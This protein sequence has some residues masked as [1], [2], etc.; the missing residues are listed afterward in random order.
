MRP[1]G[2]GG[3]EA[4][5]RDVH[6]GPSVHARQVDARQRA[7]A[8]GRDPQPRRPDR[9]GGPSPA[10]SRWRSRRGPRPA[11]TPALAAAAAAGPI[12]PSPPGD[13]DPVRSPRRP[14]DR[15]RPG[16]THRPRRQRHGAGRRRRR[17]RPEPESGVP[18]Q[19]YAHR[20]PGCVPG[21]ASG[22]W[23][24]GASL[25]ALRRAPVG[26]LARRLEGLLQQLARLAGRLRRP[27]SGLP[28]GVLS[29]PRWACR[30]ILGS[31]NASTASTM[32][33]PTITSDCHPITP[34][35]SL[36]TPTARVPGPGRRNAHGDRARAHVGCRT[37]EAAPQARIAELERGFRRAGLPLFIEDYSATTDVFNRV[38]PLLGLVFL[39]EM[40]GR[41][42]PRV[43]ARS[44]T[45][46]RSSGGS[47]SCWSRSRSINR[48][49]GNPS[50]AVP[51]AGGQD[52]AGRRSSCCRP[53]CR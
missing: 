43:V 52:R 51:A 16:R 33:T 6:E 18:Q 13:H 17:P 24:L 23:G 26:R 27:R 48:R 22:A 47:R 14:R 29:T 10:R 44:R 20:Q 34:P 3:R 49:N 46:P 15:P 31:R 40:L 36:G 50:L 25:A 5:A 12:E 9:R 2:G 11:G 21:P 19:G 37:M 4:E 42:Q 38:V 45:S 7:L 32:Q 35:P 8:G 39:G 28:R 1:L 30:D 53:S 41:A